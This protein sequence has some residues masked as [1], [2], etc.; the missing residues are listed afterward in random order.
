MGDFNM[1][2]GVSV[3]DI[4]GNRPEDVEEDAFWEALDVRMREKHPESAGKIDELWETH[5]QMFIDIALEIREL[6]YHRGFNEGKLE[7]DLERMERED[8]RG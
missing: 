1:P 6:A 7:A 2:P 3:N 4:P 8:E 5:E